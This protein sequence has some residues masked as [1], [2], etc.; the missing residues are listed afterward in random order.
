MQA[1]ASPSFRTFLENAG[2][3]LKGTRDD[4]PV[5]ESLPHLPENEDSGGQGCP[6]CNV[7]IVAAFRH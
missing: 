7:F 6:D 3:I 5:H 1:L 2:F 4:S